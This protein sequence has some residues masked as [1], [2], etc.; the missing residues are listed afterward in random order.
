MTLLT[1]LAQTNMRGLIKEKYSIIELAGLILYIGALSSFAA[2]VE[3]AKSVVALNLVLIV[4]RASNKI[5][6]DHRLLNSLF[7]KCLTKQ[8]IIILSCHPIMT[9]TSLVSEFLDMKVRSFLTTW[10]L[11]RIR[12]NSKSTPTS[13]NKIKRKAK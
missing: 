7:I 3:M 6:L 2:E 5:S 8:V 11:L 9:K 4:V 12:R 10:N 1:K 13:Q